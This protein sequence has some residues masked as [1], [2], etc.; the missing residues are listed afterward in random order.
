[1]AV[2][3][4]LN[5]QI[6]VQTW[7]YSVVDSGYHDIYEAEFVSSNVGILC[8]YSGLIMKTHDAG[9]TWV[10]KQSKQHFKF[11]VC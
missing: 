4:C 8:G 3:Q 1:M 2:L 6:M 10:Q 11:M 5:R 9:K 7:N